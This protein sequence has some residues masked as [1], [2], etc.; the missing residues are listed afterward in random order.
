MPHVSQE[1]IDDLVKDRVA[2]QINEIVK[3]IRE[4]KMKTMKASILVV[5][6][7][8]NCLVILLFFLFYA[9]N[10]FLKYFIDTLI[11]YLSQISKMLE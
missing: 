2:R 9:K 3:K 11:R 8:L 10:P 4:S 7:I 1:K 5:F 6:S